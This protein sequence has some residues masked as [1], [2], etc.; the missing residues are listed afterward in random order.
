MQL[1]HSTST[2]RRSATPTRVTRRTLNTARRLA[3]FTLVELLVVIGIIAILVAVLL[4]ALAAA[5][6]AAQTVQCAANLRTVLQGMTMFAAQNKL[7]IPGSPYTSGK[8]LF[9]TGPHDIENEKLQGAYVGNCPE[10]VQVM[11]WASP[12]AQIMGLHFEKAGDDAHRLIRFQQMRDNPSF[13]CPSNDIISGVYAASVPQVPVGPIV[14]YNTALGFLLQPF[15]GSNGFQDG[16]T[17]PI[18]AANWSL[19]AGYSPK[20]NKVGG[21][22][23]KVYIADGSR[24]STASQLPDADIG[25]LPV[26]GG[27]FADQGA[28]DSFSRAWCA[29]MAP[30]NGGSGIYDPRVFFGRHSAPRRTCSTPELVVEG[31]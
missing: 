19:P 23:E 10:I 9:K 31:S 28:C 29:S 8:F 7:Q 2:I 27:V 18:N 4:P 20:V 12:I 17:T 24:Y 5:R 26:N 22:S 14:S 21:P 3:A 6:R 25:V 11:D 16:I 1:V 30:G 13:H 15:D